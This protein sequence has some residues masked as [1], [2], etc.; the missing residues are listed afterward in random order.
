VLDF[1]IFVRKRVE[2]VVSA[3]RS[4]VKAE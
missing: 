1:G 4:Q 2:I 3:S